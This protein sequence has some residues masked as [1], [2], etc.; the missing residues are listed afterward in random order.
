M[1]LKEYKI[2]PVLVFILSLLL[3]AAIFYLNRSFMGN[4]DEFDHIVAG[5]A[6]KQG[7]VLYSQHFTNHFP[8]PYYWIYLF[9]PLWSATS[10]ART[11]SVFRLSLLI[12]YL[13]SYVL[14]FF[15][16]K[17]NT[18]KYCFSLWIS[19]ISLFFVV[20]LGYIIITDTFIAIFVSS[21]AWIT[22][23]I[24]LKWEKPSAYSHLLLIIF[25]SMAFWTQPM[26]FFLLFVPFLMVKEK[27]SIIKWSLFTLILNSIP[28][29]FFYLNK[30]LYDF[31]FQGFYFNFKVYS[32]YYYDM[33]GLTGNHTVSL[34]MLYVKNEFLFLKGLSNPLQI[35]QFIF[36][37]SFLWM[38]L[39]LIKTR[40]I[41]H[42]VLFLLLFFASRIREVKAAVGTSFDVGIYPFI[43][44]ASACFIFF[45]IEAMKSKKIGVKLFSLALLTIIIVANT[46]TF[47]QIFFQS[48]K[49]EYNYHVFWSPKQEKGS[50][51]KSLS[52]PTESVLM[53]PHD[54][55]LYYFSDRLSPDRFSYWFPWINAWSEYRE[56]RLN[57]LKKNP[58]SVIYIGNLGYGS[59]KNYYARY[60]P[61]LTDNYIEVI[62]KGEKT[63]VWLRKDLQERLKNIRG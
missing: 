40:N 24:L 42:I 25:G 26:L 19:I 47:Q 1:K 5:Y 29:L 21:M 22:L 63:G 49:P 53:Y 9:T 41:R 37:L 11:L 43:M 44:L 48:L 46:M 52:L 56:E 4:F 10:P 60:F 51:I 62:K 35:V 58:P 6:M 32:P 12:L 18:S 20:Y 8:L 54:V 33:A 15:T 36:H 55:D 13:I 39:T 3:F 2:F 45:I 17:K 14:V 23:P 38:L 31:L 57:A 7:R 59:D 61:Q 30:Q 34:I 16:F 28:L 27:K 50:I